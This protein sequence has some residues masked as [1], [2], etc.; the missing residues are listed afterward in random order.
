MSFGSSLN[1]SVVK[2]AL[3]DVW[4][5]EVDIEKHPGYADATNASVFNQKTSDKAAEIE[6]LFGGSGAWSETAEEQE[7]PEGTP[8]ITNQK[9]FT[10]VKYAKSI[11]IPKEFFDDQMHGSYEDMVKNFARRAKT[12]R[13]DN[14]MKY[15]R[16]SFTTSLTADGVA[17]I[18]DSH[19]TVSGDT[20]DN[21]ETGVLT[22]A[23]LNTLFVSLAQQKGQDGVIDGQVANVLLVPISLFKTACEITKSEARA[24]TPNNDLCYYSQLY[25]GLMI[26]TSPYLGLAAGGSDTAYWLLSRN[27]GVSRWVRESMNTNLV[28]YEYTNNDVYVYKGRFREV[29]GSMT[30]EGIVG[31]NGTV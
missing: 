14:A 12:T 3:D 21:L 7:L 1:P 6:E 16:N 9:T 8:R 27:H 17:L 2:T 19:V 28:P 10:H 4:Y 26:Y 22:E 13:D 29:V 30:Y 11:K 20:V 25:P 31:S 18:S 15:F 24:G 5:S 23:N